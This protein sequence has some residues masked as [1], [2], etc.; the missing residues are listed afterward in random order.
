[1]T[2]RLKQIVAQFSSSNTVDANMADVTMTQTKEEVC[3]YSFAGSRVVA[4]EM[5]GL[6]GAKLGEIG[7]DQN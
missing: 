6:F 7:G 3:V 5:L 1:M 2:E 4:V